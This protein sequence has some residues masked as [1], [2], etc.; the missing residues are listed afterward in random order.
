MATKDDTCFLN[1]AIS[2]PAAKYN[3]TAAQVTLRWAVQRGHVVIPKSSKPER[4]IENMALFDFKLT[5]EEMEAIFDLN[6][7]KRYNDPGVF[8]EKAFGAFYPIWD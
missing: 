4:L 6:Q 3:K 2:G 7:N 5:D 8:A 1:E